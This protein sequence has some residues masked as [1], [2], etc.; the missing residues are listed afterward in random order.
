MNISST[1]FIR[2]DYWPDY[3]DINQLNQRINEVENELSLT[4]IRLSTDIE[5][6]SNNLN[7]YAN[8]QANTT[9]AN[10][11]IVNNI[12]ANYAVGKFVNFGNANFDNAYV[13]NLTVNKPVFDITLNTPH[14]ENVTSLGGNIYDANLFNVN[15]TGGNVAFNNVSIDDLTA[16]NA[17]IS[18]VNILDG[19]VNLNKAVVSDLNTS[20]ATVSN[21]N[22]LD[23]DVNLNKA[24][25]SDLNV[26][27]ALVSNVNILDGNVNLN[28]AIIDNISASNAVVSN[29]NIL[30]GNA[31]LNKVNISDLNTSNATVSNLFVNTQPEPVTSSAVLGYDSEGRVIPVHASFDVGF[32]EDANYLYTDHAGTAFAGT[33]ATEVSTVNNLI[34]A[35]AVQNGFNDINA[36]VQNVYDILDNALGLNLQL[37]YINTTSPVNYQNV[38]HVVFTVGQIGNLWC[39]T[40]G[41]LGT[42]YYDWNPSTNT[43]TFSSLSGIVTFNS[44]MSEAFYNCAYLNQNILITNSVTNIARL[45]GG[46]DST[47][48]LLGCKNLNQNIQIPNSVIDMSFAFAGCSNLNQNI[49]IPDSVTNMDSAFIGCVN[50]NQNIQI[51]NSVTSLGGV[52]NNCTHFNQNILIPNSVTS[53]YGLFGTYDDWEEASL[54]GAISLNQ[55]IQIPNSV[56]DMGSAFAGCSNL[57]QNILIPDSV[58]SLWATFADCV[59][60]SQN[61]YI[62]SDQISTIAYAFFGCTL[63]ADK[64]IHIRSSIP[65]DTSN[66]I[67]NSLVNNYTGINWTGRVLNDLEE[68]TQWP[69][70]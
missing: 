48:H 16:V 41:K 61:I 23:G 60:L 65:M 58:T 25:V 15:I 40:P 56:I 32:P 2:N 59:N 52:F 34:T 11:I 63:L 1:P 22:I 49:L 47:F 7:S 26:S 5:N 20:N 14:I 39:D 66:A 54:G 13:E 29:V 33:A 69:P 28:K 30:D 70:V 35:Q 43:L 42:Q 18:N 38:E 12:N 27:S 36:N 53:I 31:V 57:N 44:N 37:N 19:D 62:Y 50:L 6:V 45:F 9:I 8:N 51:P 64:Y 68:P 24:V 3:N 17:T 21:V 55:N 67:Y 4:N 46:F 10:N